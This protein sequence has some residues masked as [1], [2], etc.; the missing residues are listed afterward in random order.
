LEHDGEI[1]NYPRGS[2]C[3]SQQAVFI[4][5]YGNGNSDGAALAEIDI[6]KVGVERSNRFTRSKSGSGTTLDILLRQKQTFLIA[7]QAARM[8]RYFGIG[9]R[10]LKSDSSPPPD[11]Y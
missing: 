5:D 7:G 1:I 2:I 3:G 4:S 9:R 11:R 8:G 6:S 10:L